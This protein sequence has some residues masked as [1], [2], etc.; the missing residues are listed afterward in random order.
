M[1]RHRGDLLRSRVCT[2]YYEDLTHGN[3]YLSGARG[4]VRPVGLV[5]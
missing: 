3:P 1:R 2:A 5:L 4:S